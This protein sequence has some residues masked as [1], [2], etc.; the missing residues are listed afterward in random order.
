MSNPVDAP[1]DLGA[2]GSCMIGGNVA[3]HAGGIHL[4]QHGPL[5]AYV[6]G[7]EAV[8]ADGSILDMMQKGVLKYGT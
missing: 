6:L 7:M 3:T 4:I 5:R 1:F 8:M 2:K